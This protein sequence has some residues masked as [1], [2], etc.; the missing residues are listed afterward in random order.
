MITRFSTTVD[1]RHLTKDLDQVEIFSSDRRCHMWIHLLI[2][3]EDAC[4]DSERLGNSL[5]LKQ[6]VKKDKI[7]KIMNPSSSRCKDSSSKYA[8]YYENAFINSPWAERYLFQT[9][10]MKTLSWIFKSRPNQTP[11]QKREKKE[12]DKN[13]SSES[14]LLLFRSLKS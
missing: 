2:N 5:S 1:L 10:L 8:S 14:N 9:K 11:N 12:T 3:S 4:S 6:F 7:K 13:S